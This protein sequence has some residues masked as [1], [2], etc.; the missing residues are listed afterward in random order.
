MHNSSIV[1]TRVGH[2]VDIG[3]VAD[4]EQHWLNTL[5]IEEEIS[6]YSSTRINK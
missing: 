3:T 2:R 1:V 5:A 4:E 6:F